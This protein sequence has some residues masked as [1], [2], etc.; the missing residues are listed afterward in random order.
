[1]DRQ[2]RHPSPHSLFGNSPSVPEGLIRT[3]QAA[4]SSIKRFP[5]TLASLIGS[6]NTSFKR[7]QNDNFY[8]SS[9]EPPM[10]D[11]KDNESDPRSTAWSEFKQDA[12]TDPDGTSPR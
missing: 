3:K 9:F 12:P 5:I 7:N 11:F 8:Q 6:Q 1:M 4:L 10:G 2:E